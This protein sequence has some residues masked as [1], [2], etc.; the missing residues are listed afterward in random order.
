MKYK[1]P[2]T[3]EM[4]TLSV[5]A[6]DTLPIGTIVDYD[7]DEV[8]DGWEEVDETDDYSTEETL[9]GKHWID[10]KPIYRKVFEY[11]NLPA[12]GTREIEANIS[13]IGNVIGMEGIG[14]FSGYFRP[15]NT[16]SCNNV[17]E[18][19]SFWYVK[20]TNKII[21]KAGINTGANY[22]YTK[23]HI[24]MEYTKATNEGGNS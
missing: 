13:N 1:D 14:E 10:G 17:N 20:S 4:K 22:C 6:A 7:G 21:I 5:K 15:I 8:P 11:T 24:I 9:T 3:G 19:V 12:G 2:V 16:V 18:Q 23:L